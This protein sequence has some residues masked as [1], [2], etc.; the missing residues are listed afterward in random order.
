MIWA[1]LQRRQAER[2]RER[3]REKE[4]SKV[5][6]YYEGAN[7]GKPFP[8]KPNPAA[9]LNKKE[10]RRRRNEECLGKGK[11]KKIG[12]GLSEMTAS[13]SL[14]ICWQRS[15]SGSVRARSPQLLLLIKRL[16]EPSSSLNG[17]RHC[18]LRRRA[19][20]PPRTEGDRKR[21]R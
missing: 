14:F 5:Y 13:T 1:N 12:R 9:S 18:V 4:I 8:R 2:A 19:G 15:R 20:L 11:K 21:E 6:I 17:L 3:G 10:N 16:F 7:H